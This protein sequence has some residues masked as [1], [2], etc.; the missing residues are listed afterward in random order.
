VTNTTSPLPSLPR[1]DFQAMDSGW[2]CA[3]CGRSSK[4][5]KKPVA[6]CRIAAALLK[7]RYGEQITV[8]ETHPAYPRAAKPGV[9]LITKARNFAA[10]AAKHVASGMPQATEEQV[11]ARF[12]ICQGC[13]HFDGKAC[14]KCGCPVVRERKFLSKLSWAGE[15][16]P[17]GKWG[18]VSS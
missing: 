6:V 14:R 4:S 15:S 17:V 1:C 13:E 8:D 3:Q 11:A 7:E 18:P 16:C 12:A 9:S 5:P 10:S 2:K